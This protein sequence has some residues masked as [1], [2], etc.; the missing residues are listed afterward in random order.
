MNDDTLLEDSQKKIFVSLTHSNTHKPGLQFLRKNITQIKDDTGLSRS[1]LSKTLSKMEQ[2]GWLES[3]KKGRSKKYRVSPDFEEAAEKQASK[4][5][6]REKIESTELAETMKFQDSLDQIPLKAAI[7][8]HPKVEENILA[9]KIQLEK[10]EG[11][12]TDI[13]KELMSKIYEKRVPIL[14]EKLE[15]EYA[16]NMQGVQDPESAEILKNYEETI[17]NFLTEAFLEK[18]NLLSSWLADGSNDEDISEIIS[19]MSDS[20]PE[21]AEALKEDDEAE[22][23]VQDM[24]RYAQEKGREKMMF[25]VSEG[26]L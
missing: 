19:Y 11:T 5:R 15:E 10:D 14:K 16:T 13:L 26:D 7:Y 8:G 24:A 25:T 3:Q 20:H 2:N 6:D 4:H 9:E 23:F 21:E 1:F 12:V 18:E 22:K 17:L